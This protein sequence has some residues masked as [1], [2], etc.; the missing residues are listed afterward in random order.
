ML[1]FPSLF[2]CL[3]HCSE[4][5]IVALS[6]CKRLRQNQTIRE[7]P[8]SSSTS[9][10]LFIVRMSMVFVVVFAARS[11]CQK[12][13]R[14]QTI[15]D[16]LIS[17]SLS[18]LLFVVPM[19]LT[20]FIGSCC[21]SERLLQRLPRNQTISEQ[22]INFSVIGFS[23]FLRS[24]PQ[25]VNQDLSRQP[26]PAQTFHACCQLLELHEWRHLKSQSVSLSVTESEIHQQFAR[27]T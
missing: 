3:Q 9:S 16:L 20:L 6:V 17:S 8:I 11:G 7:F 2:I 22:P 12:L 19:S 5:H 10:L 26:S 15:S 14:N 18:S 25:L 13:P 4:V 27:R 24:R 23:H 1:S 21:G